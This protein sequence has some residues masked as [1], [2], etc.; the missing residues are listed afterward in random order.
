MS[1]TFHRHQLRVDLPANLL[2]HPT[3]SLKATTLGGMTRVRGFSLQHDPAL[4]SGCSPRRRLSQAP[5]R[6]AL[7]CKD[8]VVNY[9]LPIDSQIQL[10]VLGT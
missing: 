9:K 10:F 5:P 1:V 3:P 8:G 6:G 2:R 7:G 4:C